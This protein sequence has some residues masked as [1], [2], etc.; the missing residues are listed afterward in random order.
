MQVQGGFILG[1]DGD[2]EG[3]FDAQ[4][5]F[6]REA[7]IPGVLGSIYL[8]DRT[9]GNGHVRA[10]PGVRN[11]LIDVPLGTN[12]TILNF[13]TEMDRGTLIEGYM[14]VTATLYDPAL[15]NYLE[16]CLTLLDNLKFVPH[17]YKPKSKNAVF[18][19]LMGVRGRLSDRQTPRVHGIHRQGLQGPPA[20]A[21]HGLCA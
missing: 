2:D 4:I 12:A 8:P 1:L 16:R 21:A 17:L 9:A 10:L 3:V 6:I 11:R 19:D 14:R 13:K 15:K 7:G 18:A 5:E 20:D